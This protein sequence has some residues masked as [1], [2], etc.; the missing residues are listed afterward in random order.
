[1]FV[2]GIVGDWMNYFDEEQKNVTLETFKRKRLP[3][4]IH[5]EYCETN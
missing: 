2:I 1:M 5:I 4:G 3:T